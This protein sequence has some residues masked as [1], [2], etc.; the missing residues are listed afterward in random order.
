[1]CKEDYEY[2]IVYI[3]GNPSSG[4]F[5]Q[6]Q[7]VNSDIT[8]IIKSYSYIVIDSEN[9]NLSNKTKI[10]KAKVYIAFSRGSRYLKKLASS[11]LKI[12]IGGISGSHIHLFKNNADNIL[13][14][15]ISMSSMQAHFTICS[16][17]KIK[18]KS[19][20]DKFLI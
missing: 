10:E 17:D 5:L 1:M 13:N 11:S 8:E 2:D 16:E 20:I 4:T 3:K 6:H 14:G 9:K 19:L 7:Q 18:I 15:D 12:S